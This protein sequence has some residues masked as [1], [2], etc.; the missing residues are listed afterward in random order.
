MDKGLLQEV[1]RLSV[2][3]GDQAAELRDSPDRLG[4]RQKDDHSLVTQADFLAH[5]VIVEGLVGCSTYPVLSEEDILLPWSE[6]ATWGRYW[7]IDPLDGTRGMVDGDEAFTVNVALIEA[8]VPVLAVLYAPVCGVCYWAQIGS[9]A[10]QQCRGEEPK[11]IYSRACPE[12]DYLLLT[13]RYF[14]AFERLEPLRLGRSFDVAH[15]NSSLKFGRIAAGEA[16]V[17]IRFGQIS[18]WD[19]AAGQCILTEAGGAVV[20]FNG[21]DVRYNQAESILTPPFL[22]LGDRSMISEFLGLLQN[23]L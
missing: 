21:V 15:L 9:G 13:G 10:F 4:V 3:A 12:Q 18:E 19:I 22:A 7:L 23:T 2:A 16:D 11:K 6:R 17:Y 5:R 8:G 14:A 20:D 1:V